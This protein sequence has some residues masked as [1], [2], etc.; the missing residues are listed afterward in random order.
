MPQWIEHPFGCYYIDE[1]SGARIWDPILTAEQI[2]Q[3]Y[4]EEIEGMR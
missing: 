4:Q 3:L 2:E 1:N